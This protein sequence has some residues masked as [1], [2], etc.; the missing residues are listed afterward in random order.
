VP[1]KN[2]ENRSIIGKDK[3]KSGVACFLAHPVLCQK[4]AKQKHNLQNIKKKLN[5]WHDL[6]I[7]QQP[8]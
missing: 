7:N 4:A 3:N 2:F 6:K 5:T 1:V 8:I